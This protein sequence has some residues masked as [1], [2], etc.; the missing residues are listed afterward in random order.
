MKVS[1]PYLF[2]IKF[3]LILGSSTAHSQVQTPCGTAALM[4]KAGSPNY[5]TYT[6]QLI[7]E[8]TT[9][10]SDRST[11]IVPVVFHIIYNTAEQNIP[12]SLIMQQMLRLNEDFQHLNADSVNTPDAFKPLVGAMDIEFCLAGVS[13]TGESTNGILRIPTG[14]TDFGSVA[15]YAVPDPVKHTSTGGSDAWNTEEYMNIWICNLVGSTAYTAPPG[16]FVD[17]NDDGIVCHYNHVG[18]S[19]FSPYDLGRSIVHDMGHWFGLKHIWGDDGGTCEGTDFMA[20]TPNQSNWSSGCPEFP[21]T[22]ACS[23]ASPGVMYMNYM[24]YSRDDC[25]NMFSL[26]QVAYMESFYDALMSDYYTVDRCTAPDASLTENKSAEIIISQSI[27]TINSTKNM[28]KISLFTVN[29][30]LLLNEVINGT[31]KQIEIP[32]NGFYILEIQYENAQPKEHLKFL[33]Q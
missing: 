9:E 31:E 13:P 20:D 6:N 30:Q 25:R 11:L 26:A 8:R 1:L 12:D 18:N 16:N 17:P 4:E 14:E 32:E 33:I 15:S 21:L 28:S 3:I 23:P 22:D 24:D 5:Y 29:G 19:G 2:F 27:V 7:G 10:K